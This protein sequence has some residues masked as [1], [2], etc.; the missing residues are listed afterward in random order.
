MPPRNE[1]IC[2]D[3]LEVLP[4]GLPEA[5]DLVMTSPP[6]ADRRKEQYGGIPAAGYVDWFMPRAKEMMRVLRR[7]GSLVI[8]IKEHTVEG[9]RSE[10]VMDLVRAMRLQ[11]WKWIEEYVWCKPSPAPGFWPTRLKDGW[12][13]C[14]HFARVVKPNVYHDQ[15]KGRASQATINDKRRHQAK[16]RKKAATNTGFGYTRSNFGEMSLPSNVLTLWGDFVSQR[17]PAPFPVGVPGFFIKLF[18]R[19][20][21]M[22][23]DPFCGSGTTLLAAQKLRRGFVGIDVSEGYCGIR[24]SGSPWG[25]GD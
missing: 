4:R 18:T 15:V 1:I 16:P 21:D 19:A 22:V 5:F 17:H 9:E 3:C 2:G 20:G 8:V 11:G 12:E 23:L 24:G 6:Y 13:H 7:D 10:Y 14:F 25:R